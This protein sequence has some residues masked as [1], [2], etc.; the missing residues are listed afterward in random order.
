MWKLRLA[1]AGPRRGKLAELR[2]AEF[3]PEA[4]LSR[5]HK[6]RLADLLRHAYA[7]TPYYRALLGSSGVVSDDGSVRLERLSS[8]PLLTKPL[9]RE[10]FEEL[11][12]RDLAERRY[13]VRMTG[14]SSGEPAHFVQDRAY[15]AWVGAV[16]LQFEGWTGYRMGDRRVVLW[17]TKAG[18][19]GAKDPWRRRAGQWLRDE[20]RLPA[21]PLSEDDLAAYAQ[22]INA[23]GPVQ[24]ASYVESAYELALV[25]ERLGLRMRYPRSIL[26]SA[27]T[28]YPRMRETI[29]RAFAAPVFDRYGS[30]EVGAIACECDRHRGL[31]VSALCQHVEILRPDG[32][33][34]D[35]GEEGEIVITSLCNYAMPLIRYRIG[36]TGVWAEEPCPCGRS[37]PLLAKVTGRV[38]DTFIRP[39][40]GQVNGAYFLWLLDHIGWIRRF[41]VVQETV[42]SVDIY[43]QQRIEPTAEER[44]QL[45]EF[46]AL[47]RSAMGDGC[48]VTFKIVPEIE[49][50]HSGKHLYVISRVRSLEDVRR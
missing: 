30:T 31:H 34:T 40:G 36:D 13:V 2:R 12:S 4:D 29:E 5:L 11:K 10:R 44:R 37:G 47:V 14:G 48:R 38:S 22:R 45:D 21:F 43:L 32:S 18:L 1:A 50:P 15:R 16:A 35:L 33:P 6:G 8:L 23:Y 27:G 24:L 20:L 28:L 7:S 49:T 39:D 19:T 17:G 41:R 25:V 26:T 46:A 3:L 42:D 9:L